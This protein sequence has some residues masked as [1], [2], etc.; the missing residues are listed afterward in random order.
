MIN[1]MKKNSFAFY[2][3]QLFPMCRDC[4]SALLFFMWPLFAAVYFSGWLSYLNMA[5]VFLMLLACFYI[6][7]KFRLE[8]RYAL[9]YP[10]S[11]AILL[12]TMMNSAVSIL[13]NKGVIWRGTHYPLKMLR[14]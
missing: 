11:I 10:I 8:K 12:F 9:L 13:K 7:K 4:V 6:S 2:K 14:N 5:N 1:G 3:Y